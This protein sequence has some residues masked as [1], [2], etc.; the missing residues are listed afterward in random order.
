M[1]N[2]G[3][4][5]ALLEELLDFWETTFSGKSGKRLT[6]KSE[7]TGN[8][9]PDYIDACGKWEESLIP[10]IK[11][12]SF[13]TLSYVCNIADEGIHFLVNCLRRAFE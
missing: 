9:V 10:Q 7:L 13:V 12:K 6:I 11:L 4:R 8:K 3:R 1:K 2:I 5:F